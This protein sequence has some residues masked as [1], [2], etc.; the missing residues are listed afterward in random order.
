[1]R[2]FVVA[3]LLFL[4]VAFVIAHQQDKAQKATNEF[5]NHAWSLAPEGH[6]T[7]DACCVLSR[8]DREPKS[9]RVEKTIFVR[10]ENRKIIQFSTET[11]LDGWGFSIDGWRNWWQYPDN[12]PDREAAFVVLRDFVKKSQTK[13]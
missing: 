5:L 8:F 7:V 12:K 1:M 3:C 10:L 6:P 13:A 4:T 9:G 11:H 2:A